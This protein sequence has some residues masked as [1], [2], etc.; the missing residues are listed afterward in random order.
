MTDSIVTW[1]NGRLIADDIKLFEDG[2]WLNDMCILYYFDIILTN[3][4]RNHPK[5]KDVIL[6]DPS[7]V[8]AIQF[9]DDPEDLD[10]L[11]DG[12]NLSQRRCLIIPLNDNS[13]P[14][15]SCGGSHWS[16]LVLSRLTTLQPWR[17]VY[18]DSA[19]GKSVPLAA[20]GVSK[21][22]TG[23]DCCI[24]DG[25]CSKQTN[26]SD[27][28]VYV[29]AFAERFLEAFLYG[30]NLCLNDISPNYISSLRKSILMIVADL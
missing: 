28:G 26:S 1:P 21:K 20:R 14:S 12:L 23:N 7:L 15:V 22:I 16:L 27:C 9:E 8:F 5:W 25:E 18:Y 13:D 24:K 2:Q 11:L 19:M 3:K 10:Q 29:L 17:F 4:Y 6:M 30:D